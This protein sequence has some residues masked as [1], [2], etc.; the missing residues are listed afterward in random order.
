MGWGAGLLGEAFGG[1]FLLQT[2]CLILD[3]MMWD[4]V[5]PMDLIFEGFFF[6]RDNWDCRKKTWTERRIGIRSSQRRKLK[7][8]L[9]QG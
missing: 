1:F 2:W 7:K 4:L 3:L 8:C 5:M 6:L 9:S